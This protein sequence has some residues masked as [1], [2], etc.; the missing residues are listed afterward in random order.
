MTKLNPCPVCQSEAELIEFG[1][2][3]HV[4]CKSCHVQIASFVNPV[5]A[6]QVW[7]DLQ[8][9]ISLIDEFAIRSPYTVDHAMDALS[10]KGERASVG[11][12]SSWLAEANYSYARRMLKERNK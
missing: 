7:N 11:N 9:A 1:E 3:Y 6:E 12:I 4:G 2:M 10:E 5:D 8:P